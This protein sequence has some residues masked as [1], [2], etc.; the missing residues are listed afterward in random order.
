M[1]N[2]LFSFLTASS[3]MVSI[4]HLVVSFNFGMNNQFLA[5]AGR[6]IKA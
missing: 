1:L 2:W 5:I 3:S 4:G 6:P